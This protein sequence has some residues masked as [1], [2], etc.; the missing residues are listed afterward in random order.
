MWPRVSTELG[1][2]FPSGSP[3][4]PRRDQQLQATHKVFVDQ[5]ALRSGSPGREQRLNSLAFVAAKFLQQREMPVTPK[6][7][8]C[9]SG[10]LPPL[11]CLARA[12]L[13]N[14]DPAVQEQ[15][16]Q[17]AQ[18][19]IEYTQRV[20]EQVM[21]PTMRHATC[22]ALGAGRSNRGART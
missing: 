12:A 8:I 9:R 7:D 18:H 11:A 17:L 13:L 20:Y 15:G 22:D 10:P 6:N 1:N 19:F 5:K 21:M 2:W 16:R 14:P 4:S 3:G